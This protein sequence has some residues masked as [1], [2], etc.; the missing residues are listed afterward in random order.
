VPDREAHR[1]SR[2]AIAHDAERS[3]TKFALPG[4]EWLHAIYFRI[5]NA[6]KPET[7]QRWIDRIIAMLEHGEVFHP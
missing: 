3:G 4:A 5:T 6:K 7:R 1:R 2:Y